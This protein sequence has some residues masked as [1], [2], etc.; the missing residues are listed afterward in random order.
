MSLSDVTKAVEAL[1]SSLAAVHGVDNRT[2]YYA[3]MSL[4]AFADAVDE[5]RDAGFTVDRLSPER[6]HATL[7]SDTFN[8]VADEDHTVAQLLHGNASTWP[9]LE[10]TLTAHIHGD[11]VGAN[12]EPSEDAPTSDKIA[13]LKDKADKL[14][15][16]ARQYRD[17]A[18]DLPREQQEALKK[19]GR[20]AVQTVTTTA[21]KMKRGATK[22]LRAVADDVI[23][24]AKGAAVTAGWGA[25]IGLGVI[26]IAAVVIYMSAKSG[27]TERRSNRFRESFTR[28]ARDAGVM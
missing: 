7:A 19:V 9:T 28:G 16:A 25:G 15:D 5:L 1:E 20:F 8:I 17:K 4:G 6:V 22:Q 2:R 14:A 11:Y 24:T 23:N 12:E 27:A 10:R 13:W 26:A 18:L 3:P 21:Q